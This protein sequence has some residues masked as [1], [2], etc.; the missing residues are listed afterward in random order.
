MLHANGNQKQAGRATFIS[1]KK[2]FKTK[3]VVRD[4]DVHYIVI[5]GSIHQ[6]NITFAN[7]YSPNVE[8]PK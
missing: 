3:N 1:D 2:N 4:K 7:I 8:A 5:K 6:G